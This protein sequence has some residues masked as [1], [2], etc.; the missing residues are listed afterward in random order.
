MLDKT[1]LLLIIL[2]VLCCVESQVA[3]H[4]DHIIVGA[5]IS[6]IAASL[7]L[8]NAG[9]QHLLIEAKDRI[10]GRIKAFSFGGT[11]Q[12]EGASYLQYPYDGDPI[13]TL[14]N[15]FKVGQ[16]PANFEN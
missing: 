7:T 8:T 1:R 5:G 9:A 6:G 3:Q 15:K 14:A 10:G 11:T 2:A 4:F 13:H 12:D 16:I